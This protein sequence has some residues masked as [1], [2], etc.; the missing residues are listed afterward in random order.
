MGLANSCEA[1]DTFSS[2][3][4]NNPSAQ[5]QDEGAIDYTGYQDLLQPDHIFTFSEE[6]QKSENEPAKGKAAAEIDNLKETKR[7]LDWH[8]ALFRKTVDQKV[9]MDQLAACWL[10]RWKVIERIHILSK[11]FAFICD[12]IGKEGWSVSGTKSY[13]L[14]RQAENRALISLRNIVRRYEEMGQAPPVLEKSI[15]TVEDRKTLKEWLVKRKCGRRG[16]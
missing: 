10:A 12:C 14:G 5:D 16:K 8:I 11:R 3:N 7:A 4:Y 9:E 15:E 13:N 1:N 2:V 6:D